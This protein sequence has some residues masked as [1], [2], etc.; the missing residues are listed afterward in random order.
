M[1][2]KGCLK[3][4]CKIMPFNLQTFSFVCLSKSTDKFEITFLPKIPVYGNTA[5]EF[6]FIDIL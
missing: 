6:Y 4:E 5:W 2:A 3:G 1:K